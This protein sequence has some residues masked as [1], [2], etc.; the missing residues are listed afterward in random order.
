M[1]TRIDHKRM[2]EYLQNLKRLEALLCSSAENVSVNYEELAGAIK[3]ILPN[4]SDLGGD[5]E[6]AF[7]T[8][9][10]SMIN[11]A[12]PKVSHHDI[13]IRRYAYL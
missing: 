11:E 3:A 5:V 4:S 13:A 2:A 9:L 7:R 1:V 8:A 6:I 10:N 12:N